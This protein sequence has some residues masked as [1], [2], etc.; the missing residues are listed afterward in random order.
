MKLVTGWQT[1]LWRSL[2]SWVSGALGAVLALVL[3]HYGIFFAVIPF[4]PAPIQ[5][6]AAA[7]FGAIALW[8]A[9][10]APRVIEQPRLSERIDE[11]RNG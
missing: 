9:I 3:A 4:L 10:M 11:K 5:L 2:T 1:V 7:L 6:P 8:G